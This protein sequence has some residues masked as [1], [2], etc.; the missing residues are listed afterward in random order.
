MSDAAVPGAPLLVQVWSDYIC[1]FCH[2]GRERVAY[3]EREH[4]AEALA[5][6]RSVK[7]ALDPKGIMNPGKIFLN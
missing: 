4:G 3:L 2:I 6:M 5:A 7:Q 1:P